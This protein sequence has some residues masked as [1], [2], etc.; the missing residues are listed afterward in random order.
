MSSQT[1]INIYLTS[2]IFAVL[3]LFLIIDI[4]WNLGMYCI[5]CPVYILLLIISI[6]LNSFFSFLLINNYLH[7]DLNRRQLNDIYIAETE[8]IVYMHVNCNTRS[9]FHMWQPDTEQK[10][11]VINLLLIDLRIGLGNS[12]LC[13]LLRYTNFREI[14]GNGCAGAGMCMKYCNVN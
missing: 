3:G 8:F 10:K 13:S 2:D 7:L 5:H 11:I 12:N 4:F 6:Q 1:R 14:S 9:S